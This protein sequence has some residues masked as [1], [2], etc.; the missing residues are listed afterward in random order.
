MGVR[1]RGIFQK[2]LKA[3]KGAQVSLDGQPRPLPT[4]GFR[5]LGR[6]GPSGAHRTQLVKGNGALADQD[7]QLGGLVSGLP[8]TGLPHTAACPV[9][10]SELWRPGW[11]C[12]ASER[13][14]LQ[15]VSWGGF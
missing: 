7:G 4:Q 10:L 2:P 9:L 8:G 3:T 14:G 13:L 5:S 6:L 11:V 15:S 12:G 1:T